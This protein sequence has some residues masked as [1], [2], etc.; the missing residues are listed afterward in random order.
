MTIQL[1][2]YA[3]Y[4]CDYNFSYDWLSVSQIVN[5]C[6]KVEQWLREKN[7]LQDSLPK[8]VDPVLWSSDI[9]SRAEELNS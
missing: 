1:V 7:Q 2:T 3:A 6:Y 4:K 5:E 8:N 9:K